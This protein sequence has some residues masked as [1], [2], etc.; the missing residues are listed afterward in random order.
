MLKKFM[1]SQL[2]DVNN[3]CIT[4]IIIKYEYADQAFKILNKYFKNIELFRF[5]KKHKH[6]TKKKKNYKYYYTNELR[7]LVEEKCKIELE[8][9]KYNFEN[10]LD[11]NPIIIFK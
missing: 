7:K 10:T 4:D 9:F 6:Q 3:E 1:C 5:D 2:F 8:F 11:N